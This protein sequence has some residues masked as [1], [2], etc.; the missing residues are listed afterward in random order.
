MGYRRPLDYTS[1][2]HQIWMAGV[3]ICSNK[4][5]G[6]TQW[7]IKQDLYR[8]KYLIE[9]IMQSTPVFVGEPEFV[10]ELEKE[11]IYHTLKHGIQQN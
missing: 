1:V 4:N 10:R 3:E 8:L 9:G 5:D 7:E 6:F 11:K 2:H